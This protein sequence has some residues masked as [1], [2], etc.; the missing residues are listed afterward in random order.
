VRRVHAALRIDTIESTAWI[1]FAA[2]MLAGAAVFVQRRDA[3][4]RLWAVCGAV[5]MTWALGPWLVV[6]GRQTPVVLPALAIRFVPIVANARIPGR[7]MIVVY[8]AVSM[9]AAIG[10]AWLISRR[11]RPR[12]LAWALVGL[13]V[14]ECAPAPPPLYT[15]A[16]A[17]S[18]ALLK[19]R[20]DRGAVC[21][22][23][24]GSRDGFGE[25]GAF[26]SAVLLHQTI[27]ERPIVGG[28][29]ARMAPD[30]RTRYEAMPVIGSLLR[31]SSGGSL[32]DQPSEGTPAEASARL[33][34]AGV[35]FVV[36]DTR[37]AS[38]DL[39]RYVQSRLAL[40][41]IAEEDGR[42]FYDVF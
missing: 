19:S 4:V 16:I 26:D 28:F 11:G 32:S 27:H 13:L 18:Y 12:Y 14:I 22:L 41:V 35:R 9:L 25:T 6:F 33:A 42:V 8:L 37:A 2:L 5:F 1:P 21:E 7:A 39:I 20:T 15:P 24:L 10:T 38:P 29:I 36:L 17:A 34:S 30:V 3:A 23:P 40:R 31:L